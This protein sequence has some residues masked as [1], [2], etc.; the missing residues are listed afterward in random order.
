MVIIVLSVFF[1]SCKGKDRQVTEENLI[2]T[3]PTTAIELTPT[4]KPAEATK[5]PVDHQGGLGEQSGD[6]TTGEKKENDSSSPEGIPSTAGS[7]EE[8]IPN[9]YHLCEVSGE[10]ALVEGDLNK[11]GIS[12]LALVIEGDEKVGA[13]APRILIIAFGKEDRTY[14]VSVI[15][16]TA[17]LKSDEGGMWGDPFEGIS[18]KDGS[19]HLSFYGGSAWRW[20]DNYQF[21]YQDGDWYLI[22]ATESFINVGNNVGTEKDYNLLT[23]DYIITDYAEDGTSKVTNG[24]F[25]KRNQYR[26]EDFITGNEDVFNFEKDPSAHAYQPSEITDNSTIIPVVAEGILLGGYDGREWLEADK[27][28]AK[29]NGGETYQLFSDH[30]FVGEAEGKAPEPDVDFGSFYHL[31]MM[32]N[33]DFKMAVGSETEIPYQ[34]PRKMKDDYYEAIV[35]GFFEELGHP[36]YQ[37]DHLEGVSFDLDQDGDQEDI[38]CVYRYPD[39]AYYQMKAEEYYSYTLLKDNGKTMIIDEAYRDIAEESGEYGL[40]IEKGEEIIILYRT[41]VIGSVDINNDGIYEVIIGENWFEGWGYSVYEY[42]KG[43]LK[44]VL[45]MGF[46][47]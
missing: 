12:D 31:D 22:G 36:E 2:T 41:S 27:T 1:L 32:K 38:I 24:S 23:G 5:E 6:E 21:R 47:I 28:A 46:G 13:S 10:K 11:D 29:L 37:L 44:K 42:Q 25:V 7:P 20:A 33:A 9:G 34:K 43:S 4:T 30:E 3:E 45:G 16:R 17:I 19:I 40:E 15:A 18:I 35:K 26:L 14:S 8:F 39:S